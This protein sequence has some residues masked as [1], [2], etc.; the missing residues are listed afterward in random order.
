MVYFQSFPGIDKLNI[1]TDSQFTI[2]CI[3]KWVNGWI[4][5]NWKLKS[6]ELVK[7]KDDLEK[8][9]AVSKNV[10]I[11]WVSVSIRK[12]YFS[13]TGNFANLIQLYQT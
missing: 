2:N 8:L 13:C 12:W 11:K 5:N 3:T 9:I 1:K 7:N 6:G 10:L 4:K